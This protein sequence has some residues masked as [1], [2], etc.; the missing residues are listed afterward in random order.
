M[1]TK[2]TRRTHGLAADMISAAAIAA[3]KAGDRS[4]VNRALG[5]R[6][7]QV[8][9]CDAHKYPDDPKE[10]GRGAAPWL[11]SLLRAKRLRAELERLT[12]SAR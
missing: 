6:P 9:P 1:P 11:E 2:R 10:V 7:W 3:F 4:G 8:S 5:V 12:G